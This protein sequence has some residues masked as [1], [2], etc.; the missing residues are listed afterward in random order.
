GQHLEQGEDHVL[1]A[2]TRHALVDL[3]LL[4]DF[5]QLVRR[6]PLQ[7]AQRVLREALRHAR[8]RPRNVRLLRTVAVV[9]HATVVARTVTLAVA[10]VAEALAAVV[11]A[12]F[13]VGI[14]AVVLSAAVLAT[15]ARGCGLRRGVAL[16]AAALATGLG[17]RSA[18]R[19]RGVAAG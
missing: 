2:G 7:V 6:H 4:G 17:G 14:V 16:A 8:V 9:L 3:Q 19:R 1:L 13:A 15:L 5:Q 12:A 18:G 11:A 10:A